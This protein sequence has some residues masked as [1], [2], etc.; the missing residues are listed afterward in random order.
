MPCSVLNRKCGWS[1]LFESLQLACRQRLLKLRTLQLLPADTL[2]IVIGMSGQ[3]RGD[4]N[5]DQVREPVM[6]QLKRTA[7]AARLEALQGRAPWGADQPANLGA[8]QH[9]RERAGDIGYQRAPSA[10]G[11]EGKMRNDKE[12]RGSEKRVSQPSCFGDD[13]HV[14]QRRT[15]IC[16]LIE[17][18][19]IPPCQ[20]RQR[21]P[22][23]DRNKIRLG[24]LPRP[25]GFHGSEFYTGALRPRVILNSRSAPAKS[26]AVDPRGAKTG[27]HS[28][29][30]AMRTVPRR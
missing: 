11:A 22:D 10:S 9:E 1:W 12:D 20:Q 14:G 21:G 24:N 25:A 13:D 17:D 18:Q 16:R 6:N 3:H 19:V 4:I 2:E 28:G 23:A 29:A 15:D 8:D 27:G 26:P 7:G 30:A 5:I